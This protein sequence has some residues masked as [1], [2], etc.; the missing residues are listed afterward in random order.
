MTEVLRR[1]WAARLPAHDITGPLR[2]LVVT[3]HADAGNGGGPFC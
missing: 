3:V 1:E 2:E